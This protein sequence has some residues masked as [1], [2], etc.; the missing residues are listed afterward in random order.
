ML[1]EGRLDSGHSLVVEVRR[2]H[3][4]STLVFETLD[5]TRNGK[6]KSLVG[7]VKVDPSPYLSLRSCL[8]Q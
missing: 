6:K 8:V 7:L 5:I 4:L 2:P 1:E 3:H